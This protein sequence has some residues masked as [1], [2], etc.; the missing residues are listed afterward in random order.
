MEP[1]YEVQSTN[2]EEELT[3]L[4]DTLLKYRGNKGALPL[5]IIALCFAAAGIV[6]AVVVIA[7][8]AYYWELFFPIVVLCLGCFLYR[9]TLTTGAQQAR[10]AIKS[11]YYDQTC[12]P[13]RVC[14]DENG[15]QAKNSMRF[16]SEGY[17]SVREL[18]ETDAYFFLLCVG[19]HYMLP[20][21]GFAVGSPDHFP[22]F[23]EEKTGR[24]FVFV[25]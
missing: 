23:L 10:Q 12:R 15:I 25:K 19:S 20:K 14:F 16:M 2:L 5:R 8:K 7:S 11:S 13:S 18:I 4:Y 22:A 24:K 6:R 1:I 3:A 9:C 21:A 17:A